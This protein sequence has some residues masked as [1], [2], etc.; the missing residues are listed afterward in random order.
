[1][2]RPCCCRPVIMRPHL[3]VAE[4]LLRLTTARD[5]EA[6]AALAAGCCCILLLLGAAVDGIVA[7]LRPNVLVDIEQAS[8][9]S[10]AVVAVAIG[11]ISSFRSSM[12]A[13][14]LLG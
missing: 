5:D 7:V 12:L 2:S 10:V 9:S 11:G 8:C 1:M 4:L 3:F 6:V 13:S 14:L